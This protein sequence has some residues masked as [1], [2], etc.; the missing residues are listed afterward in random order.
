[1]QVQSIVN[2]IW[3]IFI[4][5]IGIL[6]LIFIAFKVYQ[7]LSFQY[8]VSIEKEI[9]DK[10][11]NVDDQA[12]LVKLGDYYLF[13]YLKSNTYSPV[14]PSTYFKLFKRTMFLFV[15]ISKLGFFA[16]QKDNSIFP[17]T[18]SS[19]ITPVNVDFFPYI[20]A[21]AKYEHNI[22]LR[23]SNFLGFSPII[24]LA[25]II[26]FFAFAMIL[27]TKHLEAIANGILSKSSET[28]KYI[29]QNRIK[30]GLG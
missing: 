11:V 28:A 1:M 15:P 21:R 18:A 13:H 23:A 19:P 25:V 3:Y 29:I 7:K 9:G 17:C 10:T 14:F 2:F 8:F 27:H 12:K 26:A 30:G 5:L 24:A 16:Y 4:A 22:F 6:V 20:E